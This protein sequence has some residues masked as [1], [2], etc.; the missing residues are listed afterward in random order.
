MYEPRNFHD[1]RSLS[2]VASSHM[3]RSH[4]LVSSLGQG[5]G[6]RCRGSPGVGEPPWGQGLWGGAHPG[7]QGTAQHRRPSDE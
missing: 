7:W 5:A 6:G 2:G 3:H 1:L 4:A